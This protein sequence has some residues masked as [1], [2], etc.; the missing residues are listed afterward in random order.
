MAIASCSNGT[1]SSQAAPN[2]AA[3]TWVQ[4]RFLR[5][6]VLAVLAGVSGCASTG[7][8]PQ[9]PTVTEAIMSDRPEPQPT[10]RQPTASAAAPIPPKV[11]ARVNGKPIAYG[12]WFNLLKRSHG[13][14]ALQQMLAVELARQAA[15]AKGIVLTE[16]QMDAALQDAIDEIIGPETKDP[17]EKQRIIEA[18]LTRRGLSMDEFRLAVYRNAYLRKIAEGIV[19]KAINDKALQA[20]FD[21]LYGRKV[22]IRHIQVSSSNDASA[23]LKALADG[24]D[25]AAAA[26]RYSQNVTTAPSG[27]L[28]PAFSRQDPTT[29]LALREVA[30]QLKPGQTAGPIRAQGALHIIKLER[31]LPPQPV[32]FEQVA[33]QVGQSLR[34]RLIREQVPKLMEALLESASIE[35]Y[36]KALAEQYRRGSSGKP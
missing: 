26:R 8:Q 4:P 18:V 35:I 14:A 24:M 13:L 33:E 9:G 12:A 19:D 36:D 5:V 17:A 22:Q 7:Q 11:I 34:E 1:G 2:R 30:F 16:R 25:F 29:P 31:V 20:E 21:R 23:V 6:A 32:R 3:S 28:L 15:E 10:E 27:G